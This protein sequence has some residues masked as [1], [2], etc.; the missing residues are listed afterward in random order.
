MDCVF[1]G[2]IAGEIPSNKVYEDEQVL[3]FRDIAPQG[4][5]TYSGDPEGAY[6]VLCLYHRG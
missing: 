1:C 2:I 5:Y 3:V 4:A 6:S